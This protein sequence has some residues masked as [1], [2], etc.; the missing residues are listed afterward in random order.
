M[1]TRTLVVAGLLVA[2]V[3]AG[4]VSYYASS[5]PDGLESVAEQHGFADSAEEHPGSGSPLS[6]YTVKG[7]DDGRLSGGLAGVL[8]SLVVLGL[9]VGLTSVVRRGRRRQDPDPG[10]SPPGE[11]RDHEPSDAGRQA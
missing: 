8:G 6:D 1:R 11:G 3:L 10:A 5:S 2:L 4:L 9:A 7:V